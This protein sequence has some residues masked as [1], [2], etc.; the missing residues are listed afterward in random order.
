MV[1]S[2]ACGGPKD[3]SSSEEIKLQ[4]NTCPL[5]LEKEKEYRFD[6]IT[7]EGPLIGKVDDKDN[8]YAYFLQNQDNV[9]EVLK[10]STDLE[11]KKKYYIRRAAGPG[12]AQNPRI[13]GGDAHSIIVW[14]APAFKYIKFDA[15]FKLIDEYRLTK[16]F[17]TFLYSGARYIPEQNLVVDGFEK[18]I[19]Y[20]KSVIR[21]F[22]I[23]FPTGRSK[24]VKDTRLFETN[25]KTHRKDND[26]MISLQPINFGWFFG[27][28]YILDKRT[29]R[30][31][32]MDIDGN[33]LRDIKILFKPKSFPESLRREWNYKYY[34]NDEYGRR[35]FDFPETLITACW[36]IR[37]GSGIAVGRCQNYDPDKRDFIPADYFDKD[38][39]YQGKIKLPYFYWWNHPF[40][41]QS[42]AEIKFYSKDGKLYFLETRDDDEYWIVRCNIK[43][44]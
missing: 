25:G 27:H 44:G 4:K 15:D 8:L 23:K 43:A 32:K 31:I 11:L 3:N 40:M 41:G 18:N 16:N 28:L 42:H 26:K 36:L 38:L 12:E 21:L 5:V 19:T 17:G 13:Y 24:I 6:V 22:K 29:Y 33:I 39:N 20:Y 10:L 37:V 35:R 1:L 2:A 14:D 7:K 9:C 30:L 34:P